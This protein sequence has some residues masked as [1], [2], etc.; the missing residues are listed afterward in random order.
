MEPDF[1]SRVARPILIVVGVLA[2]IGLI[3]YSVSRILLAVPETVATLTALALAA[4]L[5]ALAGLIGK[6][7]S[8]TT[9]ALGAGMGVG[10]IGLVVAG[11]IAQ[12]AG[13]RDLHAEEHGDEEVA[14]P[15]EEEI[16]EI[17]E[18]ALVWVAVDVDY[19]EEVTE[20][21]AG[22]HTIVLDNTGANL[23][24]NV[25]LEGTN[26][27]VHD[28]GGGIAAQTVTLEPGEYVFYCDVPGHRSTMEGTLTV[29]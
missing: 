6:R 22:E 17:P 13:M 10:L 16:T 1:R 15:A 4:Y 11:I 29:N 23:P 20:A 28:D 14:A 24:H 26:I 3:A 9:R 19:A 21:T 5:L 18:D 25:V 8:I 2:A 7:R 27:R 12:Q